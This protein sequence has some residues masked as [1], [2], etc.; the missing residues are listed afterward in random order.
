LEVVRGSGLEV[1]GSGG[2]V[3]EGSVTREAPG[4]TLGR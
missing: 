2:E 3:G 1:V 4:F